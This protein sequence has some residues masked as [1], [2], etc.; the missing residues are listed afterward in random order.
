MLKPV[1]TIA[2]IAL[3]SACAH[4]SGGDNSSEAKNKPTRV[5]DAFNDGRCDPSEARRGTASRDCQ[6]QQAQQRRRQQ[7]GLP[8]DDLRNERGLGDL[9]DRLDS[10]IPNLGRDGLGL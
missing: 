5:D 2:S 4:Q 3:L 9:G 10:G 1:L 7:L 6:E 8:T